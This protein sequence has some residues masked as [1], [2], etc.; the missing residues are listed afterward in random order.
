MKQITIFKNEEMNY[1]PEGW[2]KVKLSEVIK[3]EQ[4][5]NYIVKSENYDEQFGIP[6]LTA[7][8]TF[9][10][11]Y[12][13]EDKSVF[14]DIPVIIFDDFTT[15]SR[16]ITFPFK[17]KSSALKILRLRNNKNNLY[18]LY[19]T[20]QFLNFRPGSEHKRFWISEFSNLYIA[21]PSSS[22]QRKIAEI[23]ETVDNAIDKTD[24]LIEKYNRL[25]QGLMQE[26]L[27]KG[28]DENG[29]IRSEKTHKFKDSPLGRIPEEWK[30]KKLGEL[31]QYEQPTK[32]IVKTENYDERFGVPVLTAGKTF[33]LG[34][35]NEEDGVFKNIPVIIF[36]DF[37]T[38]S[39]YISFVF[40]VKSSA[41]K[42]LRLKD[43]RNSLF[44]LYNMIQLLNYNPGSEHKRFWISE[45]SNLE[46]SVPSAYEQRHI[47]RILSQADEVIE[48]E[49]A[50]KAKL[51]RIKRGLMED[52]LT[53]R[54]RVNDL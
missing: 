13:D 37:T 5:T 24:A 35:T 43:D 4:A 34:Y 20:M 22:E 30:I 47:A 27:T 51:E 42:L 44:F 49:E 7:G 2:Q 18:C 31:L 14:K 6:V 46:I 10:L 21:L 15:E 45:F 26:L 32:Y 36:D 33:I 50:Y 53:G 16:Y 41:L 38:G 40:K 8:K 12:T 9:I 52:L 48:K 19:A 28:I 23:L 17:V 3:Y 11:G 25:K 29:H 39:R 54:V 1:L